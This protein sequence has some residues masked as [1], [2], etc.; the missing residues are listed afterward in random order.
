[1][2]ENDDCA[3]ESAMK[4]FIS[5]AIMVSALSITSWM[6]FISSVSAQ[7]QG[8]RVVSMRVSPDKPSVGDAVEVNVTV[9]NFATSAETY[10]LE[11]SV[12]GI[13]VDS[14]TV[15]LAPQ[16]SKEVLLSFKA[17]KEGQRTLAVGNIE[18]T[19][20]VTA[21]QAD[22]TEAKMRVG[23]TV[24]LQASKTVVTKDEDALVDLFWDNSVLNEKTV[25]IEV[26]V[27]VPT[28]LYLHSEVGAMACSAGTCKGSFSAPP[29]SA[30]NMPI[31]VKADAV[32]DYFLNLNGR[33]WPEGEKDAW[34]P[35]NL[36]TPVYVREV[37]RNP[38]QPDSAGN[39]NTETPSTPPVQSTS[40]RVPAQTQSPA[41]LEESETKWW[42]ESQA[43][44]LWLIIALVIIA[45]AA[46]RFGKDKITLQG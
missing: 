34:N 5:A 43:L 42:L 9:V 3:K 1:M 16:Q 18:Q 10:T 6:W 11:L 27:Q 19:V 44:V 41:P 14:Q 31:I 13:V 23:T 46:F 29:G 38:K 28:G 36:S 39:T 32:G 21:V 12:T 22:E 26:L 7:E 25:V 33:Y 2:I 35:V 17:S 24:R 20:L 30:R 15:E 8:V 45:V 37:S 4:M 40:E